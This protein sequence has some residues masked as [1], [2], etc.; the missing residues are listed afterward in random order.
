MH[1]FSVADAVLERAIATASEHDAGA[2]EELTIELGTSTHVNPDQLRFCLEAVAEG[3]PAAG[4]TVRIERVEPRGRCECGWAGSPPT[5]DG[6]GM[7]APNLRC[8]DCGDR[9]ELT[10][11]KECRLT[12]ITTPED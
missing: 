7:A 11:G 2:I 12:S 6:A 5:I 1:E 9:I 4:A 3:T 10:R 8:P